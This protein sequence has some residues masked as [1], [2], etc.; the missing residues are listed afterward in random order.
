MLREGLL[1]LHNLG[2]CSV[3]LQ[4][5]LKQVHV[6]SIRAEQCSL[7]ARVHQETCRRPRNSQT[8][9][10]HSIS[11]GLTSVVWPPQLQLHFQTFFAFFFFFFRPYPQFPA[12]VMARISWM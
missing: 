3:L 8:P 4:P 10:C 1:E 5:P 7:M 12:L 2:C 11:Q 9:I 6:E